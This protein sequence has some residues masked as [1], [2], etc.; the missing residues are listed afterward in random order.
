MDFDL[1]LIA[2]LAMESRSIRFL[3]RESRKLLNSCRIALTGARSIGWSFSTTLLL[4]A[5]GG[6]ARG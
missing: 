3:I 1:A 5:D 6:I 2:Y 4:S